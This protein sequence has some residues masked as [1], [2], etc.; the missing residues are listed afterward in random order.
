MPKLFVIQMRILPVTLS[1]I[2]IAGPLSKVYADPP[3]G[4][5]AVVHDS[6]ITLDEV[7]LAIE[8]SQQFRSRPRSNVGELRSAKLEELLD[9]QLIL[10]EFKTAGY[11]LP[12][13]IVDELVQEE[14]RAQFRDRATATKSLQA[15]GL[16]YEKFR[17]QLRD[18]F[19]ITALRQKNIASEI[20]I[21]PHKME[22][23]Y[24]AHRD[25]FKLEDE[26]KMRMIVL[27]KSTEP[28]Q[29]DA[30]KLAQEIAL[31]LK[32]GVSFDEMSK[33]YSK[34]S[35]RSTN[36]ESFQVSRLRKELAE[37]V[38][39]LKAGEL[40]DVI[41]T[42][43]ACYLVLVEETHPA[44]VKPLNEVREEIEKDLKSQEQA[45]LEKQW[46]DR[47]KKKTFFRYF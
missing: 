12:E 45:R 16:T 43:E 2:L 25:D 6:V 4:I 24:Q 32:G 39:K 34:R 30:R 47:L 37:A 29:P 17:Q 38:A 36:A 23:Y 1:V 27:N 8:Q 7:E 9:R 14:S 31:K 26:V 22:T 46:I 41:D 10:H 44:H 5:S 13:S 19:V 11:N 18:R 40:S 35:P 3:N 33:L 15:E 21:S 28:D 42:P 20:I